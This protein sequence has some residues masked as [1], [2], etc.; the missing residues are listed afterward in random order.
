MS[1]EYENDLI[2]MSDDQGNELT[3]EIIDSFIYSGVEYAILAEPF[4]FNES[5]EPMDGPESQDVYVMQIKPLDDENDELV[6]VPEEIEEEVLDYADR[7]LQGEFD[8][9]E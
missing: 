6:P 1:Q 5:G 9:D 2:T 3:M 4:E 7:Y 8:E